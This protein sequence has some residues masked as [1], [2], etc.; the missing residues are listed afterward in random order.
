MA[1]LKGREMESGIFSKLKESKKSSD[2]IKYS[3]FGYDTHKLSKKLKDVSLENI[4]SDL[5]DTD[6][7][8]NKLF[9]PIKKRN[10]T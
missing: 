1:L 3:S 5:N 6:N 2:D 8:D 9:T 4:L 10:R 7:T